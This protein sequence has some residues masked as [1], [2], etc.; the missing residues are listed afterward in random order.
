MT[1]SLVGDSLCATPGRWE[2]GAQR[3][4]CVFAGDGGQ[5]SLMPR[6]NGKWPGDRHSPVGYCHSRLTAF[7][8]GP[9]GLEITAAGD[10]AI[11][12]DHNYL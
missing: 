5:S 7:L 1:V 8:R 12:S 4:T 2:G 11:G 6:H 3:Y 10:T 9:V